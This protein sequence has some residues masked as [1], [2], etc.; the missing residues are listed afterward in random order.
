MLAALEGSCRTP[1]A[2]L[3]KSGPG[4]EIRLR[5]LIARPDG[6]FLLTAGREGVDT[7]SEA[8]GRDVGEELKSRAGP[9]FFE[10]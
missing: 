5:G 9:R 10:S 1:I 4:G 3:A 2:G 6:R 8:L 7:E